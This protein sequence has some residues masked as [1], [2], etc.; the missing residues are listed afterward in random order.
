MNKNLERRRRLAYTALLW[1]FF[2]NFLGYA[3]IVPILPSWQAQF[4]FNATK[5]TLLVSLWAVPMFLFGPLTGRLTDKFGCG[6][7]V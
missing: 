2:V 3:F 1:A 7:T 5:A 4:G 6:R